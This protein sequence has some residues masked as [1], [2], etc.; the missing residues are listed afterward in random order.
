MGVAP[1]Q[2]KKGQGVIN[3]IQKL[4]ILNQRR[5]FRNIGAMTLNMLNIKHVNT[6]FKN[7]WE[8]MNHMTAKIKS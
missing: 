6:T 5:I 8:D 7:F 3:P 2:C 4:V 1:I